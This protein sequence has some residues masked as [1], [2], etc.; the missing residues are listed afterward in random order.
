MATPHATKESA[1]LADLFSALRLRR[2]LIA[3]ILARF[4]GTTLANMAD[5]PKWGRVTTKIRVEKPAG[6]V[7]R[8]SAH[9][10][11][12]AAPYFLQDQFNTLQSEKILHPVIDHLNLGTRFAPWFGTAAALPKGL[13][14]RHFVD[15]MLRAIGV[16]HA[17]VV[18]RAF[19]GAA[20]P[21]QHRCNFL[22][23]GPRARPVVENLKTPRVGV[24]LSRVPPHSGEDDAYDPSNDARN[25][26]GSGD[27]A[28]RSPG[29]SAPFASADRRVLN[30][31]GPEEKGEG[32]APPVAP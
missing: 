28:R 29:H 4:V 13:V 21:N 10:G 12:A 23:R 32:R 19:D 5:L 14:F 16:S 30:E 22:A 24:V 27:S 3:L 25:R 8:D 20:L 9:G 15:Q 18:A 1:S 6:A 2:A 26:E 11:G 17:S 31:C 7:P